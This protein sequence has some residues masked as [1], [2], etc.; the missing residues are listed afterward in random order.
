M[1]KL[2]ELFST[3]NDIKDAKIKKAVIMAPGEWQK[4]PST[5]KW[6]MRA[7]TTNK[8]IPLILAI[9]AGLGESI[10]VT[11]EPYSELIEYGKKDQGMFVVKLPPTGQKSAS[12]N[13]EL[14]PQKSFN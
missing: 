13:I 11:I 3:H 5:Q 8:T 6:Q 14:N 12:Y 1:K 7:K 10:D 4:E 9:E 2:E